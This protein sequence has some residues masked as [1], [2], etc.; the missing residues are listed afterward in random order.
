VIDHL[1]QLNVA[2]AVDVAVA[3][4]VING[5]LVCRWLN[6]TMRGQLINP[7]ICCVQALLQGVTLSGESRNFTLSFRLLDVAPVFVKTPLRLI[8][9]TQAS[10]A[11]WVC[12]VIDITEA[13]RVG[14]WLGADRQCQQRLGRFVFCG[15]GD[16]SRL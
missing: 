15:H 5:L 12:R 2:R 4:P 10:A 9:A 6:Q 7:L 13:V 3:F 11:M 8:V 14:L 16:T 1:S